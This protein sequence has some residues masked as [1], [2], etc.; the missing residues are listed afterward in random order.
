MIVSSVSIEDTDHIGIKG[1]SDDQIEEAKNTLKEQHAKRLIAS[2]TDPFIQPVELSSSRYYFTIVNDTLVLCG[3]YKVSVVNEP[4]RIHPVYDY[5]VYS[6]RA[7]F[8]MVF[9]CSNFG[10]KPECCNYPAIYIK[11]KQT[12]EF[13]ILQYGKV[14]SPSDLHSVQIKYSRIRYL[15]TSHPTWDIKIIQDKRTIAKIR[16]ATLYYELPLVPGRFI[17][18]DE[19]HQRDAYSKTAYLLDYSSNE[20]LPLHP[21]GYTFNYTGSFYNNTK[22]YAMTGSLLEA[23]GTYISQGN[24]TFVIYN[25]NPVAGSQGYSVN[26]LLWSSVTITVTY[27]EAASVPTISST[28]VELGSALT[29]YTNRTSTAATHTLLFSFGGTTGTIATGVTES[30]SWTPPLSL[31]SELPSAVSGTCVITCQTYINGNQTGTRSCP[32]TLTVPASVIP[33]ITNIALSEGNPAL[34]GTITGY[35]RS[36]SRLTAAITAAGAYGSTISSY[37]ATVDGVTYSN[38]SFTTS[39]ALSTDGDMTLSVTVTDSRGRSKSQAIVFSVIP[40]DPPVITSMAAERCNS[41]GSAPQAD[42]TRIRFSAAGTV[43]PI[44]DQNTVTCAVYYRLSTNTAWTKSAAVTVNNYVLSVTNQ[45][46][47]QTFDALSSFDVMVRLSDRFSTVEQFV[48]V[49]TKQVTIDFYRDGTGIA[50]G[51]VCENNAAVEIRQDWDFYTHGQEIEHMLLDFAHPVGSVIETLSSTFNPNTLWP[52][53]TWRQLTDVFLFAAGGNQTLNAT[54]GE[55]SHALTVS[56]MTNHV[57][58]MI[59]Y[60]ASDTFNSPVTI[61]TQP[62]GNLVIY[63]SAGYVPYWSSET[64]GH[65]DEPKTHRCIDLGADGVTGANG[66]GQA[67]NL[68]PPFLAVNI[69]TRLT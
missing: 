32:L 11:Q 51:K 45:R 29:L 39:K 2:F 31:A 42:G 52:W 57:H 27:E 64:Y 47:G 54:G 30:V 24:N 43:A 1:F 19:V 6:E 61:K 66:S 68:M 33:S 58:T 67:M 65:G 21:H 10:S 49:G 5:L 37:R 15:D 60:A 25:P 48:S 34:S 20:R 8:F 7:G 53:T 26:Y 17:Y 44:A 35:V 36:L 63:D 40:Y 55:A 14:Y 16:N 62:D 18:S 50:F 23:M 38:A 3:V 4:G 13:R 12:S 28:S 46:L 9:G 69:W 56:E 41:S 22:T 59:G